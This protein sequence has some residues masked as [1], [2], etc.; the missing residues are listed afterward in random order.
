MKLNNCRF[1]EK[2]KYLMLIPIILALV[3]I[4]IGS[5][6][7]LNFDYDFRTVSTFDVKFNTTVT[8]NEYKDLYNELDFMIKDNGFSDYRIER[9]GEGAKNGLIVSIAN[10][11]EKL[12]DKIETLKTDIKDNLYNNIEDKLESSIRISLSD[13]NLNLP[14]NVS[15]L[16]W[17]S[18]LALACILIFV[19]FY[20]FIRY[21]LV[22]GYSLVL[23]ILLGIVMLTSI[24]ITARIP[25]NYYFVL[26]YFVMILLSV[27]ITTCINNSIKNNLNLEKYSKYSNA[28]RIYDAVGSLI[29]NVSIFASLLIVGLIALMFFVEI[30]FVY[31][32]IATIVGIIVSLFVSIIFN[33]SIWSFWYKK[34]KDTMLKRRIEKEKSKEEKKTDDKIVV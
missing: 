25:F 2:F 23:S 7:N 14:K 29:K 21:N 12:N 24:M 19:F 18:V 34:D 15:N 33:T 1:I 22:T 3:S 30:S 11:D 31:L 20:N 17:L 5:I 4:V 8:E 9:I 10:D 27:F 32:I 28:E 6:F 16:V 13:T 26:P